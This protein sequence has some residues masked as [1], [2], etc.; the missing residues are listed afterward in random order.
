MKRILIIDSHA[1]LYKN[2]YAFGTRQLKNSK[3]MTTSALFG[4]A[5]VFFSMLNQLDPDYVCFAFDKSRDTFRRELYPDYKAN[6]S[7]TP[8]E[9]KEQ[10]PYA[11]R[12]ARSMGI[13]AVTLDGFEADD[14]LGTVSHRFTES[15]DDVEAI[16]VTGDRDSFQLIN[17]KVKVAY[18]STKAKEGYELYD[19]EKIQEKYEL[20]PPQLI[21]VKG[22]QGDSSDNIPGVSG[23]GEK[24]ALK[25]IREYGN[26]DNV[27]EHIEEIK[28]KL[29][30]KLQ[31]DKEKAILSRTLGTIKTDLKLDFTLDDLKWEGEFPDEMFT[32]LKELEFNSLLNTAFPNRSSLP[33]VQSPKAEQTAERTYEMVLKGEELESMF[34]TLN[35]ADIISFD[36]ETKETDNGTEIVGISFSCKEN[37]AWY[38]PLRHHYLGVPKQIPVD[39]LTTHL[40]KLFAGDGVFVAHNLKY[41]MQIL[42]DLGISYPKHFEDTLLLAHLLHP[43]DRHGLKQLAEQFLGISRP[44][45]KEVVGKSSSFAEVRLEHALEY[46]AADAADTLILYNK[47]TTEIKKLPKLEKLY[48]ELEL[49]LIHVLHKME[50]QGIKINRSWFETLQSELERQCRDLNNE[51]IELAGEEFNLNSPKQMSVILFEKL[52]IPT[53]GIKKTK[54][55]YTTNTDTLEKLAEEYPICAKI[56]EYKHLVKL[57]GTYATPLPQKCDKEDRIHTSFWQTTVATGRLSSNDPNLQNIPVRSPWGRKIRKGFIPRVPE[58]KL[59]SIDYSQIE[60]R[61]LAHFSGDE[62]LLHAFY[63]KQDIHQQTAARVFNVS[64][65]DITKEQRESA[66]A[67]NFGIIYGMGSFGLSR[68]LKIPVNEAKLFIES[69]FQ[70]YPGIQDF[71]QSTIDDAMKHAEVQTLF[72]RI[73]PIPELTSK[74]RN[75]I[76]S[77]KRIAVNSKIQGT[78]AELMKKAMIDVEKYFRENKLT[79]RILIQVHDELIFEMPADEL[80]HVARIKKIMESVHSFK[81]PLI[82]DVEMG[83]NWGEMESYV[84]EES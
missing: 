54:T 24:T 56:T 18:I 75:I 53:A 55:G 7:A 83:D 38:V 44:E 21:D 80:N 45:F 40:K 71:M 11:V 62:N 8:E 41:D 82:C 35:S 14:I 15:R 39:T 49:P 25:L 12:F 34:S 32:L 6:R 30:E 72:G 1:I 78:A 16:L 13:T 74:N 68:Q 10:F 81:V 36:T 28:G 26:M 52:G 64:P 23:V 70:A 47:F 65:D 84:P 20:E 57:L 77:G 42:E 63:E 17:D 3:G 60:L 22:L 33:E 2:H 48:K 73:R 61:V 27:Y 59:V 19:V 43:L 51:V 58:W 4:F 76:E 69:Y 50:K 79:S 9:L 29:K 66:K 67:I 5:R 37:H 46:A 31:N